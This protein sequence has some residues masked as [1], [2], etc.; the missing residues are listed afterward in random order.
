MSEVP[1]QGLTGLQRE[2]LPA[3]LSEHRLPRSS[4]TL[5]LASRTPVKEVNQHSTTRAAG[6]ITNIFGEAACTCRIYSM[7]PE[8]WED[9]PLLVRK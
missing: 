7:L 8:S 9:T 4:L 2:D 6:E 5:N 1:G 3:C